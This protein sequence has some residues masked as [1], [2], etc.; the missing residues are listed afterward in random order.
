MIFSDITIDSEDRILFMAEVEPPE[1]QK[2]K[3][4]FV[5]EPGAAGENAVIRQLTFFPERIDYLPDLDQIQ[6]QNRFGLFRS[7]SDL[8][9]IRPLDLFPSF[10][11]GADILTGKIGSVSISPDGRYMIHFEDETAAFGNLV[12][13]SFFDNSRTII[14]SNVELQLDDLPVKWSPESD[15]VIYHKGDDLYYFSINQFENDRL[16]NEEL[17]KLGRGAMSNVQWGQKNELYYLSGT[18]FYQIL[19]VE[20]FTR[21]FYREFLRIGQVVG[22]IPFSFESNFDSF[23][24]SPDSSHILVNKRGQTLYVLPLQ[25]NKYVG[26]SLTTGIPNLH[27]PL[28]VTVKKVLWSSD[29]ILTIMVEGIYEESRNAELYRLELLTD[30]YNFEK[31]ESPEPKDIFFGSTDD[32]MVLLSDDYAVIYDYREWFPKQRINHKYLLHFTYINNNE[33]LLA[34]AD[35]IELLDLRTNLRKFISFSR[36]DSL[37][38]SSSNNEILVQT[39]N[40]VRSA[41]LPSGRWFV[42]EKFNS[43][44]AIQTNAHYRTYLQNLATGT[45]TNIIMVR[46]ISSDDNFPR[47]RSLFS[48]PVKSYEPF[49]AEDAALSLNPFLHGSRIRR[50]EVTFVF[51]AINSVVGLNDIFRVLDD[52]NI[53]ATFFITGDFIRHYPEAVREIAHSRHEVGSLF[54]IYFDMSDSRFQIDSNFIRQGLVENEDEYFKITGRDMSLLWHAPYY[55]IDPEVLAASES[56]N[57]TYVSRDVDSLDWVPTYDE[58]GRSRLY[59]PPAQLIERIID[60]KKPGSVISMTIGTVDDDRIDGGRKD[61]LFQHLDILI[62]GLLEQ[63]YSI[64]P[65]STLID[66][67]E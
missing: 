35:T 4:A 45:Y 66:H 8:E 59:F 21:S 23:W 54:N 34:G 57:Y 9:D 62:N 30:A 7:N 64:V 13:T 24:V 31:L 11:A 40:V 50:R 38:F 36:A 18:I 15:F 1:Y 51:N 19:S 53:T 27:L 25:T 49:P 20:F 44:F 17:R 10:E 32:T 6:I 29:G 63:G 42:R 3:T 48:Q 58:N 22:R 67:A 33:V 14:S 47:T 46:S 37:G 2:Y 43:K 61:Y 52:Y 5:A 65:V 55:Y 28:D 39:R 41:D 16:F 12:L 60:N 26:N 56:Q